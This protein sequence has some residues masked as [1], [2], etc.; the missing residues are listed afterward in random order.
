MAE[1]LQYLDLAAKVVVAMEGTLIYEGDLGATVWWML[2][3]FGSCV[4]LALILHRL[5]SFKD[6]YPRK[7]TYLAA[8]FVFG[9]AVRSIWP[10][11]D[12]ERICFWDSWI[13]ATFVGRVLATAA[14]V[15]LATQISGTCGMLA[16]NLGFGRTKRVT[17]V[18]FWLLCVA[19]CCCWLGVTSK[20]QVWHV[21][22]ESI[23]AGVF[24]T[25]GVCFAVLYKASRREVPGS[26]CGF[27]DVAFAKRYLAG[28]VPVCVAFVVFMVLVDIPMYM[29]RYQADQARG[30]TYL[31]VSEG[32]LDTMTCKEV[33]RSMDYWRAEMPWMTGYFV[34]S[35]LLSIW[36]TWGPEFKPKRA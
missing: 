6:P 5:T 29:H 35:M 7:M 3:V 1:E 24:A 17:D 22:E 2:L 26:P 18:L 34:G 8:V 10:R 9:C 14:E 31:W 28:G 30:E 11:V 32:V 27:S 25:F 15:C 23:W 33:S 16:L 21:F 20:R 4:N 19:R 36:L 13:S 12:V